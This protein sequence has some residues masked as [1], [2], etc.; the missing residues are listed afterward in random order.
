MK[1]LH[2]FNSLMPSCAEAMLVAARNVLR[3]ER[4]VAEVVATLLDAGI[5][6][7]EMRSSGLSVCHIL[8]MRHINLWNGV[9]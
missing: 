1:V 5:F 8:H 7:D 4:V 3:C 6:A 2:I 9:R